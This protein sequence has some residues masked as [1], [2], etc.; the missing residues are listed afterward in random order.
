VLEIKGAMHEHNADDIGGRIFLA[1]NSRDTKELARL[2]KLLPGLRRYK[3]KL[4]APPASP[5]EL[6][7][8]AMAG[9]GAGV[10][11]EWVPMIEQL[12][13]AKA[14]FFIGNAASTFS[15]TVVSERDRHGWARSTLH[16]SG[17]DR[18]SMAGAGAGAGASAVAM[19]G[20]GASQGGTAAVSV[21][22]VYGRVS[23]Q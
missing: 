13:C 18:N 11:A 5:S 6:G 14:N 8:E 10:P 9:G 4:L 19:A 17:I 7:A 12:V 21:V 20:A 23:E 15:S 1:T 2:E 3:P 22:C 16:F